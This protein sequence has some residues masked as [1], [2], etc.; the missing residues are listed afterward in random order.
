MHVYDIDSTQLI[1]LISRMNKEKQ[2]LDGSEMS[3]DFN[4][5]VGSTI[6]P[7][8]KPIEL[9]LLRLRKKI[10]AGAKFI[11]TQVARKTFPE[12]RGWSAVD[13]CRRRPF[14]SATS[15]RDE[16]VRWRK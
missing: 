1:Q 8:L 14:I 9:N 11:Q 6:N 5:L 4:V 2:L 12:R 10:Q 13:R 16:R 3:G 15:G 7:F